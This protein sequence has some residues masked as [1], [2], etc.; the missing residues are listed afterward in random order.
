MKKFNNYFVS[1]NHARITILS[2]LTRMERMGRI[3]KTTDA[4]SGILKVLVG[5]L[6]AM[7]FLVMLEVL[8]KHLV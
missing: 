4:E 8:N 2:I 6:I 1:T 7:A 3:A 5:F